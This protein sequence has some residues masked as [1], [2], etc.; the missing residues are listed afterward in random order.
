MWIHLSSSWHLN[1]CTQPRATTSLTQESSQIIEF[2]DNIR[3]DTLMLLAGFWDLK[4]TAKSIFSRSLMSNL[5]RE[6]SNWELVQTDSRMYT[7]K[8][9]DSLL[10]ILPARVCWDVCSCC[11]SWSCQS[12]SGCTE[13][14]YKIHMK[15]VLRL[16]PDL[17][18][19]HL[20][21]ST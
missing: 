6:S 18:Q 5:T 10:F 1:L 3:H 16:R 2:Q 20:W 21:R 4:W 13:T 12:E 15:I 11:S 19:R 14:H 8:V 7:R 9:H 17:A